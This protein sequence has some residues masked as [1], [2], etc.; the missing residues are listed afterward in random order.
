MVQFSG[1]SRFKAPKALRSGTTYGCSPQD[2]SFKETYSF[3]KILPF[4]GNKI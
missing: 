2:P 1:E 4:E 3:L